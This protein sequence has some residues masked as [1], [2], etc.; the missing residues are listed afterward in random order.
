MTLIICARQLLRESFDVAEQYCKKCGRGLGADDR[1][2]PSC[3]TP[4]ALLDQNESFDSGG[5][6]EDH[7]VLPESERSRLLEKEISIYL[8]KGFQ[9]QMRTATT[10][11]LVKPKEFNSHW[12]L[13][14]SLV[15]VVG[16]VCL[17]ISYAWA[18]VLF[19]VYVVGMIVYLIHYAV[20]DNEAGYF[21]VDEYGAVR[22][23]WQTRHDF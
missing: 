14:W 15:L 4:S 18:F 10:A 16:L 19:F 23:T 20:L 17:L 9:V 22:A 2:C 3:G 8:P 13:G 11:Q 1:F 7:P 6:A 5:V 21:W 12:V